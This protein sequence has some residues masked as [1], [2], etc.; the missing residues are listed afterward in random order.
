[1]MMIEFISLDILLNY[2]YGI[3]SRE[4]QER[5]WIKALGPQCDSYDETVC[6]FFDTAADVIKNYKLYKL[7][8]YQRDVLE[9]FWNVFD[10]FHYSDVNTF[11]EQDFI[12]TPQWEYV[13]K[14]AQDVIK[15]FK[16][17]YKWDD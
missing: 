5:V 13:M 4:Y 1:M 9:E 10:K 15:A 12:Y 14:K 8:E 16:F 3:S 2:V 17:V 11:L 6:E 7:T